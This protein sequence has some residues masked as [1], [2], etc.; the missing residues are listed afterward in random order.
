MFNHHVDL[1]LRK[2]SGRSIVEMH[3]RAAAQHSRLYNRFFEEP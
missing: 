1:A 3:R 2:N